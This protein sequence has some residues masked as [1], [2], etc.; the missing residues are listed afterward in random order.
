MDET[1][2]KSEWAEVLP[3]DAMANVHW[4]YPSSTSAIERRA[5][6]VTRERPA[7]VCKPCHLTH[8]RQ[9][10]QQAERRVS[11]RIGEAKVEEDLQEDLNV[12]LDTQPLDQTSVAKRDRICGLKKKV[13]RKCGHYR[14]AVAFAASGRVPRWLPLA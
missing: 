6:A 7:Y 8:I 4:S 5:V 14:V 3:S 1:V 10:S 2:P 9:Q 13:R 11:T 12:L